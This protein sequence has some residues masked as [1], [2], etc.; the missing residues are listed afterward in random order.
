M[1][2]LHCNTRTSGVLFTPAQ[3]V[4]IARMEVV[5]YETPL[6]FSGVMMDVL[7]LSALVADACHHCYCYLFGL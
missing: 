5:T 7:A 3:P 6:F 1:L 2:V 4:I